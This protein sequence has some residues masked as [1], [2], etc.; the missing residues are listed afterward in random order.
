MFTIEFD[1]DKKEH[2]LVGDGGDKIAIRQDVWE[3][4]R[5]P[6]DL[7]ADWKKLLQKWSIHL[8]K[9]PALKKECPTD[10]EY[11]TLRTAIRTF[12]DPS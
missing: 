5:N 2:V 12:T 10:A 3:R 7:F 6:E 11:R 4:L 8:D 9:A 1:S